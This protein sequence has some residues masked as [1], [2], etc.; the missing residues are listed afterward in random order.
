[1]TNFR[2]Q[3]FESECSWTVIGSLPLP[4]FLHSASPSTAAP[5]L[6]TGGLP[7]PKPRAHPQSLRFDS[8][9]FSNHLSLEQRMHSTDSGYPDDRESGPSKRC[10]M[11]AP[12]K[13]QSGTK[14]DALVRV[15][16]SSS[17]SVVLRLW[18]QIVELLTPYSQLIRD[19][20]ASAHKDHHVARILDNFAATTLAKYFQSIVGFIQACHSLHLDN[21][22]PVQLAD[23]LLAMRL[24]RSSDGIYLH[25][26]TILKS[27]RWSVRHLG[28]DCFQ[29]SFD[30]LLS[31]FL[32]DKKAIDKKES[33]PLPLFSILHWEKK[34]LTSSTSPLPNSGQVCAGRTCNAL[35]HSNWCSTTRT[36]EA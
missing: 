33:L 3:D 26:S 13:T 2:D 24:A 16:Q 1:M 8:V 22:T 19:V 32:T 10:R 28:A 7:L 29:C 21:L 12:S 31:K 17:S 4:E 25:G 27:I 18:S 15:K 6:K 20:M 36:S 23:A 14:L 34:I 9:A 5:P 11:S 30:S 35:R